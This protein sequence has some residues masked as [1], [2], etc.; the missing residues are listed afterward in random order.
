MTT[1]DRRHDRRRPRPRTPRARPGPRLPLV[2]GAG[3]ARPAGDRRRARLPGVGPRG[4][5][6]PGLLQPAGQRQHR[7]PAPAVVAAIQEQAAILATIAPGHR[8]PRPRRGGAADHR[9]TRPTASTRCSSPTAA[10]TPTRTPSGWRACTPAATRSC[11]PTA[12]TTATP[13]R[14]SSRPATGGGCPT[15][16]PAA[17][18]HV[19]GPYLYRSRV[20]GDHARGGVASA[21]CSTCGASIESEGPASI[22][23]ILLETDPRHRRA[24]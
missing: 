10:P 21:R 19:F 24:S 18:V 16:T 14:R 3:G 6:V 12:S 7:A 17:H 1:D 22:A 11:R 8:Q 5:R 20:L 13:A 15:S 2:V 23:A 4:R 9:S